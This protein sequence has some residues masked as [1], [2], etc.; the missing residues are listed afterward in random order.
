MIKFTAMGGREVN[1]KKYFFIFLTLIFI[2]IVTCIIEMFGKIG[3]YEKVYTIDSS[4]FDSGEI[5]PYSYTAMVTDTTITFYDESGNS[6]VYTFDNDRLV[7]VFN[8][9]TTKSEA[10]AK[11][12]ASRYKRQIGN[13]EIS[14][15]YYNGKVVSVEMDMN[16]FAE[17]KDYS[18]KE[19]KDILLNGAEIID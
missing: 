10:E 3:V 8:V 17:Y 18:M 7:S 9:Y 2:A 12:F 15:V 16:Y 5:D 4:A 6:I 13:G 19:I 14:D 1:K 11:R